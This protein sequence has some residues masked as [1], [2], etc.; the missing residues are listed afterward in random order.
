ASGDRA[1]PHLRR[2]PRLPERALHRGIELHLHPRLLQ[3]RSFAA[4]ERGIELPRRQSEPEAEHHARDRGPSAGAVV[5][6]RVQRRLHRRDEKR[7]V[8]PRR[9][10]HLS[11]AVAPSL[12][13]LLL[14][15]LLQPGGQEVPLLFALSPSWLHV[16]PPLERLRL[17]LPRLPAPAGVP[18]LWP[19]AF[20][21]R[22]FVDVLSPH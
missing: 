10:E 14:L 2:P 11:R 20:E 16:A 18:P 12:R 5:P 9:A 8:L 19:L 17:R 15:L 4:Q 21:P 22:A 1:R 13:S 6:R 7:D 3:L